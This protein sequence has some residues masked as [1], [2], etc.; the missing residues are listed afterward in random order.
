VGHQA[1]A[2]TSGQVEEVGFPH[3]DL[4]RVSILV[5]NGIDPAD[6]SEEHALLNLAN[7]SLGKGS[8]ESG[9]VPIEDEEAVRPH[10]VVY[11]SAHR[12]GQTA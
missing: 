6:L 2:T 7:H 4:G 11:P 8:L 1:V 9:I 5:Q 10:K 12:L 3:V